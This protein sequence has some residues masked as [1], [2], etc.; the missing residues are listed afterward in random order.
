MFHVTLVIVFILFFRIV[1]SLES[2]NTMISSIW[3]VFGFYWIVAG[4]QALLQDS[5]RLYW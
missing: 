1:K 2:I 5:P 3:W 4:G